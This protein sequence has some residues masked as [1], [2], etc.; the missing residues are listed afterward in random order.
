[1]AILYRNKD[2]KY[3][4]DYKRVYLDEGFRDILR[5]SLIDDFGYDEEKAREI[6]GVIQNEIYITSSKVEELDGYECSIS[7][8][9][10]EKVKYKVRLVFKRDVTGEQFKTMMTRVYIY[11]NDCE[12]PKIYVQPSIYLD[13]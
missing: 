1:M 6:T 7:T 8:L 9:K 11:I 3:T 10:R 2:L 13:V 4:E 12:E 5:N